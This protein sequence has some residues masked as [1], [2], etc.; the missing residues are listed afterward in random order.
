[1]Q[2]LD[3]G[4]IR[5]VPALQEQSLSVTKNSLKKQTKQVGWWW[6]IIIPVLERRRQVLGIAG[7]SP[8][9]FAYLASSRPMKGPV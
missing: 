7:L 9:L 5:T 1:M 4:F 2:Q 3:G 8:N 6:M